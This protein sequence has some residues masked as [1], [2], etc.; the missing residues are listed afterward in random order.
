MRNKPFKLLILCTGNSCRSQMAEAFF[1]RYFPD[2]E[3]CSA[4]TE[5]APQVH[6][7][8]VEVMREKGYDM[9]AHRPKSVAQYLNESFDA[10]LTVCDE[11]K[12]SCPVFKGKVKYRL[13]HG[14]YDPALADG[15]FEER[16]KVFRRV[17]DEI[18]AYVK[19]FELRK[20]L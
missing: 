20:C 17:R 9:S 13:H 4:G 12:E 10:V 7:F 8:M 18:E 6:P 1:R 2:W 14:F 3:I 15:T 5:P 19:G 11:A 16:I